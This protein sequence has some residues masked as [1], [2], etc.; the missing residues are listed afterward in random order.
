MPDATCLQVS[1]EA[2]AGQAGFGWHAD[3]LRAVAA[4]VRA[5]VNV[6]VEV[7]I[8]CGGGNVWR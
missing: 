7:A 3:T 1:G 5:A 6:G 8:V 4:E 2:L